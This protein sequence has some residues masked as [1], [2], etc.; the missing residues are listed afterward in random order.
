MRGGALIVTV[1]AVLLVVPTA[2]AHGL[3]ES[4]GLARDGDRTLH[5]AIERFEEA[6]GDVKVRLDVT[7]PLGAVVE[8]SEFNVTDTL[9]DNLFAGPFHAEDTDPDVTFRVDGV[10]TEHHITG[11]G[12][13]NQYELTLGPKPLG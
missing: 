12:T 2:S 8:E 3:W 11:N 7:T 4:Q 5:I 1:A 13:Y 6:D 10:R 9:G